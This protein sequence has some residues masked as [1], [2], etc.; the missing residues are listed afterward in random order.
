MVPCL[1]R[2]P[3]TDRT[4]GYPAVFMNIDG[5]GRSEGH[6]H[7]GQE[8]KVLDKVKILERYIAKDTNALATR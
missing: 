7:E 1:D 8:M 4:N 3:I 6:P 5:S 2:M